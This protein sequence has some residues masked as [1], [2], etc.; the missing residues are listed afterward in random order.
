MGNSLRS[1][2]IALVLNAAYTLVEVIA[3]LFAGSL[4]LLA[5]AGTTSP[6]WSRWGSPPALS[7]SPAGPATPKRSFGFQR[8]EILAALVNA[9]SLIVI[10][11]I[12]FVGAARRFADPPDIPAAGSSSSRA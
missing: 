11:I 2:M 7:S 8:A 1:L 5:D 3:A 4:S 6:T 12:V 10:A 9:V